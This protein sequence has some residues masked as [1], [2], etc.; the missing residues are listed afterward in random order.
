MTSNFDL[1]Y[2]VDLGFSRLNIEIAVT[3]KWAVWLTW[4]KGMWV[5]YDVGCTMGLTLGHGAWQIDRPSN[6][7]MWNSYS[8]QPVGHWMGYFFIDL[9]AKGCCRSL[10]AL[11][12]ILP[13]N[14]DFVCD[15]NNVFVREENINSVVIMLSSPGNASLNEYFPKCR[16]NWLGGIHSNK[17]L[18]HWIIMKIL[19][20]YLFLYRFLWGADVC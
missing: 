5:G 20:L 10:N 7:S 4:M 8:F 2:D 12:V 16:D 19:S 15:E 14:F 6:G 11:F 1:T 17:N 13:I 18:S 9:G 3:Q